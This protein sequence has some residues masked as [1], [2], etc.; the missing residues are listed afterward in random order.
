MF[1]RKQLSAVINFF[2]ILLIKRSFFLTVE[3]DEFTTWRVVYFF[4]CC[5]RNEDNVC[6]KRDIKDWR[7]SESMRHDEAP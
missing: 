3:N 4:V 1:Q 7:L 5:R 2:C 6:K